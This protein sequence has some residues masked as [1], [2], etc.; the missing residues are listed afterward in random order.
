LF[1]N[2][3]VH[4]L[5]NSEPSIHLPVQIEIGSIRIWYGNNP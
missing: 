3:L 4:I 1:L 2:F 5:K